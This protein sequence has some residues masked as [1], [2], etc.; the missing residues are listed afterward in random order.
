[1]QKGKSLLGKELSEFLGTD[2]WEYL[3]EDEFILFERVGDLMLC[4]YKEIPVLDISIAK[5]VAITRRKAVE[6]MNQQQVFLF[7]DLTKVIRSTTEAR[8]FYDRPEETVSF[9]AMALYTESIISYVVGAFYF[10]MSNFNKVSQQVFLDKEKA[11]EWVMKK[12]QEA[13]REMEK[14]AMTESV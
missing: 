3:L 14:E 12:K 2:R 5:K 11:C 13:E 4:I 8:H 9:G 6:M 10:K 1:M 7:V